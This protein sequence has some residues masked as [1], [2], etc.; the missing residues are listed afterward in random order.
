MEYKCY[1]VLCNCLENTDK[2]KS[3]Y[4]HLVQTIVFPFLKNI[5]FQ[6]NG[7]FWLTF[8]I[9]LSEKQRMVKERERKRK[10]MSF[11]SLLPKSPQLISEV[12]L[13]SR[14]EKSIH[15]FYMGD[16]DSL[17]CAIIAVSQGLYYQEL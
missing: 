5:L 11:S 17:N 10:R 15:V 4:I 8:K 9:S 6:E 2:K 13:E 12:G 14:T 3:N 16:R 1:V 7:H